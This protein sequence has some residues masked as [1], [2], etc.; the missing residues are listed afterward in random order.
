M[1][2]HSAIF[3]SIETDKNIAG[4]IFFI[5]LLNDLQRKKVVKKQRCNDYVFITLIV[6]GI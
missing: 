4:A 5:A 1:Q 6:C 3:S 2:K